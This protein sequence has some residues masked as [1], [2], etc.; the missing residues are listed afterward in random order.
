M[1][2][3][4]QAKNRRITELQQEIQR[5]R[6]DIAELSCPF[7]RNARIVH[8]GDGNTYRITNITFTSASPSIIVAK[9]IKEDGLSLYKKEKYFCGFDFD[10]FS[11]VQTS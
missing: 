2:E 3:D 5:L 1:N 11:I 9:R 6:Q 7:P 10:N 4:I 8:R